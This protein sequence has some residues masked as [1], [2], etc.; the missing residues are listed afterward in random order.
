MTAP[1]DRRADGGD[2]VIIVVLGI[3]TS[4]IVGNWA[5]ANLAALI[6][7][8]RALDAG[9]TDSATALHQLGRHLDDPRLAWPEPA[10]SNLPGPI[11][12]WA[13]TAMVVFTLVG[14]GV[15]CLRFRTRRHVP[16]DRRRRVGV[17][18]Q[19]RLA[20]T[21]DLAP[22]LAREVEP[23][24]L[25]VGHWNRRLVLTEAARYGKRRGVRGGVLLF[26]PSQSGKTTRLIDSVNHWTGPA[27]ISSVKTDLMRAR[28]SSGDRHSVR[29]ECS[30]RSL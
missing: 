10:A 8:H 7:R 3:V 20:T 14:I 17:D 26:G 30:T 19:P 21:R 24:R 29:R 23:G 22:L 4:V 28:R 12:Y 25:V 15:L 18:A 6:G 9:L 16:V 5:A 13:S 27:I 1:P 2:T 11:L